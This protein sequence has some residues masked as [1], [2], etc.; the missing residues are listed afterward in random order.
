MSQARRSP[1]GAL[2]AA[3]G[4]VGLQH[5]VS[6]S[7]ESGGDVVAT[8]LV[9]SAVVAA[10]A[11]RGLRATGDRASPLVE[12]WPWIV[13]GAVA[14][15][16]PEGFALVALGCVIALRVRVAMRCRIA[17]VAAGALAFGAW[18]IPALVTHDLR[19]GAGATS[20]SSVGRGSILSV[21]VRAGAVAGLP[22]AVGLLIAVLVAWARRRSFGRSLAL[23]PRPTFTDVELAS[24]A[25]R[26]LVVFA[27]SAWVGAGVALALAGA[28]IPG[29][30]AL[31]AAA[32]LVVIVGWSVDDALARRA[33]TGATGVDRTR[34][35]LA[36]LAG[37]V[38]V[39]AAVT[40]IP[41][42]VRMVNHRAAESKAARR[43]TASAGGRALGHMGEVCAP[44]SLRAAIA[45]A[46][47]VPVWRV[48]SGP[49]F[50]TH[51]PGRG[52]LVVVDRVGV[53]SVPIPP[54]RPTGRV[55]VV[56]A[57][58]SVTLIPA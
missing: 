37:V 27:A 25:T 29:R 34:G 9:L 15:V 13:P 16:R 19:A 45:D 4:I 1:V 41:P 56:Q 14:M 44:E 32:L 47:D 12:M 39:V 53:P 55:L 43:A 21:T 58:W 30:S 2:I 36:G 46:V 31:P 23:S 49:G 38:I 17:L 24:K 8:A 57:G 28:P 40:G 26:R 20:G 42:Q 33:S 22:V 54:G 3:A 18:L 7:L 10:R 6:A 51:G 35:A 11:G 50:A 5:W 48:C 52:P